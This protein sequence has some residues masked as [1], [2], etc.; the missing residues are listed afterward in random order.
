MTTMTTMTTMSTMTVVTVVTTRAQRKEGG[1]PSFLG[2]RY[3]R[4]RDTD[5][6]TPHHQQ[7]A[8]AMKNTMLKD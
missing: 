6:A 5:D 4:E 3:V 7:S 1:P 2:K 8:S